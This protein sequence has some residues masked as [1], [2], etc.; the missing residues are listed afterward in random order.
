[1]PKRLLFLFLVIQGISFGQYLK[2]HSASISKEN[3]KI[4]KSLG[5]KFYSR[6]N[7][8][9]VRKELS[10]NQTITLMLS[11]YGEKWR[12]SIVSHIPLDKDLILY[13]LTRGNELSSVHFDDKKKKQ[14]EHIYFDKRGL[15][16]KKETIYKSSKRKRKIKEWTF[17][18]N[19]KVCKYKRIV[20]QK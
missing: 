20:Q 15:I 17:D 18:E 11:K 2:V 7:T 1:M 3:A 10:N 5:I 4:L 16:I 8:R 19:G 6:A 14:S 12:D 9:N 13:Q